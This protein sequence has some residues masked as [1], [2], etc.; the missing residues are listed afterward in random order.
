MEDIALQKTWKRHDQSFQKKNAITG[1]GSESWAPSYVKGLRKLSSA[2]F[3]ATLSC[4]YPSSQ[5][6][7]V[8]AIHSASDFTQ[9][10][11]PPRK[12]LQGHCMGSHLTFATF[13][14]FAGVSHSWRS[15][16]FHFSHVAQWIPTLSGT[17]SIFP[18][19]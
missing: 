17:H 12:G 19:R 3:Q 13:L 7:I 18:L 9:Q 4:H 6:N 14:F 8:K 16:E 5:C 1:D 2:S 11:E 15:C 10:A